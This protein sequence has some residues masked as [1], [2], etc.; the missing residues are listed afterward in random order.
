MAWTRVGGRLPE[1][2]ID[3]GYGELTIRDVRPED[4]GTY[5]CTGSNQLAEDKEDAELR[6]SGTLAC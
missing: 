4:A 3:N 6:V 5:T 1:R 2:A